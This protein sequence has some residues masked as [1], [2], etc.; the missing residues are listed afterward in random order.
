M[1]LYFN[2][3]FVFIFYWLFSLFTFQMLSPFLV[4]CL[5]LPTPSSLPVLLLGC[6]STHPP[7]PTSMASI[8]YTG[9]SIEP[10]QDQG[11]FLPLMQDKATLCY[12]CSWSHVYSFVPGLVPGRSGKG[13]LVGSYCCSSSGVANPFNSFSPF[14]NSSIQDPV[15]SP[16]VGSFQH[17]LL[18]IH[19]SI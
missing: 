11:P 4:P 7:T 9:A 10:S 8:P 2:L 15:L 18:G 3:I 12:I 19:N 16:M 13:H 14:S 5:K 1:L 6:S 17:A